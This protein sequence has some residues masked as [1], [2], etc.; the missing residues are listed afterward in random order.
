MLFGCPQKNIA[1]LQR[2]Q[3]ALA[4]VVTQQSSRSCSLTST[5]LLRQLHWLPIEWR[6]K[7]KLASLSYKALHTGHPPYLTELLQYHKPARF[8]RCLQV[9]YSQ[10]HATTFHLV[11]V[12]FVSQ[13]RK[14]GIHYRLTFCSLKHSFH[15]DII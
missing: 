9:T 13:L 11:L 7:F 10:F 4:R 8:T 2:A 6:T 12:P 14:Y 3:H 1:R 15:L 5:N